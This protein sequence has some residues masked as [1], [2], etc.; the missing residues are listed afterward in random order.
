MRPKEKLAQV[1]HSCGLFDMEHEARAG[2]Y[3][4]FESESATP[5][6]DLVA[7]LRSAGQEGLA[8]R[9]MRGEWDSTKEEADAWRKSPDGQ[10]M[11]ELLSR[12]RTRS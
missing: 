5:I 11:M 12:P 10:A 8:V 4:D 1:L 7:A 2:L 9:A 6:N 3:D